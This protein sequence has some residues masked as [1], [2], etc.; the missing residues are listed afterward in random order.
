MC[1]IS[2]VQALLEAQEKPETSSIVSRDHFYIAVHGLTQLLQTYNNND[3]SV[4][5]EPSTAMQCDDYSHD[6][7]VLIL[8]L[9]KDYLSH[10]LRMI[11]TSS[12]SFEA[13]PSISLSSSGSSSFESSLG[14]FLKDSTAYANNLESLAIASL[15]TL[16]ILT[17]CRSVRNVLLGA[18]TTEEIS[19][20]AG[21]N[22]SGSNKSEKPS[23]SNDRT[24]QRT[25]LPKEYLENLNM[26]RLL[27]KLADPGSKVSY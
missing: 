10:Y 9:L 8:P 14:L 24:E 7:A 16:H 27:V 12:D 25:S 18:R 20:S 13:S 26:L 6:S 15:R 21:S 17:L 1:R 2:D 4:S 5:E 3:T 11:E 19:D 23:T 22:S